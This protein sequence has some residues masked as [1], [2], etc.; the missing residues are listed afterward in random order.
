MDQFTPARLDGFEDPVCISISFSF[1]P[2][3]LFYNL[4]LFFGNLHG[5]YLQVLITEHGDLGQGRF[6]DPRNNLS[7]RFDHLRKEVSDVQPYEGEA[8]LKTWRDSCDNA[9]SAYVKEHYPTGVCTVSCTRMLQNHTMVPWLTSRDRS[10][11]EVLEG[12][13]ERSTVHVTRTS[14]LS[15]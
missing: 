13:T 1:I 15:R 6:L 9:L 10:P 8:S 4:F 7:F 11:F 12:S 3:T 2:E 14:S 5:F